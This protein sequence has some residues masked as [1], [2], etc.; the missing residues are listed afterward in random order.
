MN[1][2]LDNLI[3]NYQEWKLMAIA[4][5]NRV[6]ELEG[7]LEER[8]KERDALQTARDQALGRAEALD[9][10]L[11]AL[12]HTHTLDM[13]AED[14]APSEDKLLTPAIERAQAQVAALEQATRASGK[15]SNGAAS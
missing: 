13:P 9:R 4:Q 8:T 6:K 7:A 3:E 2:Q 11:S 1:G 12:R 14:A 5:S 10:E 15:R